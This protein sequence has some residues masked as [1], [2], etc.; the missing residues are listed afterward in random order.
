M[1]RVTAATRDGDSG[2]YGS[3][4]GEHQLTSTRHSARGQ[5]RCVASN[6]VGTARSHVVVVIA[7]ARTST[8]VATIPFPLPLPLFRSAVPKFRCYKESSVRKFRSVRCAANISSLVF[9]DG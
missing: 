2:Q 5:Y 4:D 1:L 6:V 9:N 7:L 8:L 3:G